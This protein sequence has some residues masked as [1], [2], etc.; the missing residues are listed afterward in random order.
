M[1]KQDLAYPRVPNQITYYPPEPSDQLKKQVFRDKAGGIVLYVIG[2]ATAL[3]AFIA[4]LNFSRDLEIYAM[5][6]PFLLVLGLIFAIMFLILN[7]VTLAKLSRTLPIILLI[8]LV[9]L[10]I[11][12]IISTVSNLGNIIDTGDINEVDTALDTIFDTILNPAFFLLSAGLMICRAG[13]TMLWTST[14][15]VHE[16]I[17]GT[18]IL[19][20]PGLTPPPGQYAEKDYDDDGEYVDEEAEEDDQEADLMGEQICTKCE[21][22]LTYIKQ[23]G[24]WYCYECKEYA[25]KE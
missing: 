6:I 14:R 20:V 9:M 21:G 5:L 4:A 3:M 18:I 11:T 17:P 15:V 2:F 1:F 25:P 19:E 7:N 13:G 24:R 16:Y 23:Y 12:S 10:Y 22:Q 8:A